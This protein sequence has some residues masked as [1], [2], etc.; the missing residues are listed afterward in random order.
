[1]FIENE[2]YSQSR[3]GTAETFTCH[4]TTSGNSDLSSD[5]AQFC[6]SGVYS[7]NT[8]VPA[9][10]Y[11]VPKSA[12]PM[13]TSDKFVDSNGFNNHFMQT[14]KDAERK[15]SDNSRL[16]NDASEFRT[17]ISD[18]AQG[19]DDGYSYP[20]NVMDSWVAAN[21][22]DVHSKIGDT[23]FKG[24]FAPKCETG[25]TW[26]V[27][28]GEWKCTGAITW[29]QEVFFPENIQKS[30]GKE[31]IGFFVMPYN[32]Q[33]GRSKAPRAPGTFSEEVSGSSLSGERLETLEAVCWKGPQ[34]DKPSSFSSGENETWF[35]TEVSNLD[36]SPPNQPV[37]VYGQLSMDEDGGDFTCEWQYETTGGTTI[38][39]QGSISEIGSANSFCERVNGR[40]GLGFASGLGDCP[41]RGQSISQE[42]FRD[43]IENWKNSN[44]NNYNLGANPPPGLT[45]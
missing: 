15:W 34:T 20:D 11:F 30:G 5:R 41:F 3:T 8:E 7:R 32:F 10:E 28:Q 35:S 37:P 17:Q 31:R 25:Q 39:E 1:V 12:M 45:G 18:S 6:N 24:G 38:D 13:G 2:A 29:N 16:I 42:D 9:V 33:T 4:P 36:I 21:G 44:G 43:Q 23:D 19:L 40:G 14:L 27:D 22:S 26:K